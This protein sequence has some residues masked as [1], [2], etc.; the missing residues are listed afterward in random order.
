[1]LAITL[2]VTLFLPIVLALLSPPITLF[3]V[4]AFLSVLSQVRM[5]K[6]R[7]GKHQYQCVNGTAQSKRLRRGLRRRWGAGWGQCVG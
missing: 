1:M 3:I 4:L 5:Y 2:S 7:G 6:P